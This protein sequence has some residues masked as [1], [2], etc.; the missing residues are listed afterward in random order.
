V[1]MVA[2]FVAGNSASRGKNL[3]IVL[4]PPPVAV[5]D[6]TSPDI[7]RPA[8]SEISR[9]AVVPAVPRP[10]SRDAADT[11]CILAYVTALDVIVAANDPVPLP[12]TS[13]V[14][15]IVWSPVFVPEDVP[16]N[17]P[18]CVASD[19][20]PKS[21]RASVAVLFCQTFVLLFLT[22]NAVVLRA[23]SLTLWSSP[24]SYPLSTLMNTLPTVEETRSTYPIRTPCAGAAGSVAVHWPA[25]SDRKSRAPAVSP[26]VLRF[27]IGPDV[28]TNPSPAA[29]MD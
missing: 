26:F 11:A 23:L 29:T 2:K 7:D 19:P 5:A 6:R 8:P 22:R 10:K 14:R 20:S 9:T 12:V 21:P 16:L 25:V 18:L 4:V 17:V 15:V 1:S 28:C 13:P 3:R 24:S 27:Y